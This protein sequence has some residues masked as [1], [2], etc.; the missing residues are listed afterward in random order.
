MSVFPKSMRRQKLKWFSSK[1]WESQHW[2]QLGSV[3]LVAAGVVV[4]TFPIWFTGLWLFG[5]C[6]KDTGGAVV[7]AAASAADVGIM[8]LNAADIVGEMPTGGGSGGGS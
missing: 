4:V 8:A 2:K 6:M 1:T 5:E 7:H 3:A